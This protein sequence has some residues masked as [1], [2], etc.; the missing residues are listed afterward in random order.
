MNTDRK[1]GEKKRHSRNKI[2]ECGELYFKGS[3]HE[4]NN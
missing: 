2:K 3:N 4:N 1:G